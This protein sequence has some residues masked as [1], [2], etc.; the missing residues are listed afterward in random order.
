MG[1]ENGKETASFILQT[2]GNAAVAK[3]TADR[4]EISANGQD[5]SYV[6]VEIT[7]KNGTIQPNATN[8]LYF[9]IEGPGIIAGISNADLKDY[10]QYTGSSV[11]AWHGR[12][13]VVIRSTR[14]TGNI[15]LSVTSP[16]LTEATLSI[17][18]FDN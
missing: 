7:D 6:T 12:A 13:L 14:T 17:R 16:D 15:K 18:T 2:S 4:K 10:D 9:K 8:R 11:N 3:L 5:L 1:L